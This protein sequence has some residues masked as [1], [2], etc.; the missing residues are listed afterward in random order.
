MPVRAGVDGERPRASSFEPVVAVD[1]G[2]PKDAQ[3]GAVALFGMATGR[4]NPIDQRLGLWPDGRG[5]IAQSRRRPLEMLLVRLGHVLGDGGVPAAI[6]AARVGG[7]AGTLQEKLD[8]LGGDPGL[9][10][11]VN[12]AV[13]DRVEVMVDL[14]VVVDVDLAVL[15]L[16]EGTR[17]QR[18]QRRPVVLFEE[19][20]SAQT[21]VAHRPIVELV[22]QLGDGQV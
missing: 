3:A 4:Q 19:L 1:L 11:A 5:P 12:Q 17:R 16:D 9:E 13:G 7:E 21:V 6:E 10:L 22:A 20:V 15:P 8:G 14:D 2:E 18:S